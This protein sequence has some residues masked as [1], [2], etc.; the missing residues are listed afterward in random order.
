MADDCRPTTKAAHTW[1]RE[2]VPHSA[3]SQ[4]QRSEREPALQ[5]LPALCTH[6]SGGRGGMSLGRRSEGFV[7]LSR[8]L[9]LGVCEWR[10]LAGG[11]PPAPL[12]S[13]CRPSTPAHPPW[14]GHHTPGGRDDI[15]GRARERKRHTPPAE[16]RPGTTCRVAARRRDDRNMKNFEEKPSQNQDGACQAP[17]E[18]VR[19]IK[20]I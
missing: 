20:T 16:G 19:K 14:R 2:G 18:R 5:S 4:A 10:D 11:P 13:S 12:S 3:D 1:D 17:N 7:V 6:F 9:C 15:S 8:L